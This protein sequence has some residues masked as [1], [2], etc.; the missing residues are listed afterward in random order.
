MMAQEEETKL[1]EGSSCILEGPLDPCSIIILGATGDLASKKLIPALFKLYSNGAL[2]EHFLICGCG[3]TPLSQGAFRKRL[4]ALLGEG[5]MGQMEKL[6]SF[7]SA[8]YYHRVDFDDPSSFDALASW[9]YEKEQEMGLKGNRLFYFALPPSLY[10]R[11]ARLVGSSTL[12]ARKEGRWLRLVVEK[13]FGH[14][15]YSARELDKVLHSYFNEDEIFRIDHYLA[16]ETVQNILIFRFAN[17]L[18]E[19][20]WN[21]R[22]VDYVEITAAESIGI[23]NRAA[24]YERAGVLRDMFQNHMM[25]LLA[26]I[27][28][29]PPASFETSTVRSEKIKVFQVLRPIPLDRINDFLK[30]GQ[31]GPGRVGGRPVPGYRQE[32]WVDPGSIVPTY[33][34]MKVFLDNWRWQGVPFYLT[35]GKRLAEKNTYIAIQ[36]KEVPHSMFRNVLGEHIMA[37][38]LVIGIAP[39]ERISLTFQTKA[40]GPKICLRSVTMDFSYKEMGEAPLLDAY[41]KVLIDCIQGDQ[42]LFWHQEGVERSWAFLTPILERIEDPSCPCGLTIYEAGTWGPRFPENEEAQ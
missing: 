4:E 21:R 1:P 33:A 28:M 10:A 18:F 12:S 41:E 15:L 36:F 32:P 3:R 40:P 42:M 26:L 25:Q 8:V 31:Y 27:A 30:L 22:Y 38:R 16:K 19:P 35:S 9:L 24:Y 2:P 39:E 6:T 34:S 23:G 14:D 20:L 13:P 7:L 5:K 29:E 37:N 17:S 11:S